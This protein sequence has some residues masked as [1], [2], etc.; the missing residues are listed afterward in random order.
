[1]R[2]VIDDNLSPMHSVFLAY[3]EGCSIPAEE[4]SAGRIVD[5]CY[6]VEFRSTPRFF[7]R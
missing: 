5:Y 1:M 3:E 4:Q 7:S 6:R 2:L